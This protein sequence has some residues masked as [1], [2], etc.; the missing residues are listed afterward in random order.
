MSNTKALETLKE[1]VLVDGF[2]IVVDHKN[3]FGSRVVDLRTGK[4]YLD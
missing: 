2:H 4:Q 3:S 1:H